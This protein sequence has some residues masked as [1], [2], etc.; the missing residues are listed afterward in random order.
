MQN[1]RCIIS[2]QVTGLELAFLLLLL[3]VNESRIAWFLMTLQL[4]VVSRV[5]KLSIHPRILYTKGGVWAS[6]FAESSTGLFSWLNI[7]TYCVNCDWLLGTFRPPVSPSSI[8]SAH[9]QKASCVK[10]CVKDLL[11]NNSYIKNAYNAKIF[12]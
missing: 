2:I 1:E 12:F 6:W 3:K 9:L 8:V 7:L 11:K 4:S 5:V 10:M